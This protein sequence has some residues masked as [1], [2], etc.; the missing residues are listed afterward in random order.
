[1]TVVKYFRYRKVVGECIRQVDIFTTVYT[2]T[3]WEYCIKL[4]Y[5][6]FLSW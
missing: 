1:M 6:K 5:I 3:V 4:R 2:N